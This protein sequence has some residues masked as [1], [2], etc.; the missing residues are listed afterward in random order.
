MNG[1]K[2]GIG[3][4][5]TEEQ[6]PQRQIE[7]FLK[8]G[9][10]ER[11]IF[12]DACTGNAGNIEKRDNYQRAKT[13]ARKGDVVFFDALDRLGRN[14]EEIKREWEYFT[15]EVEC[16]VVVMNMPILDTRK[17]VPGDTMGQM[18]SEIVLTIVSYIA[19]QETQERK[20][21]QTAGIAVAKANG[22]Y[23]GK[24][25]MKID[26]ELFEKLYKEVQRKERTATYAM[27]KMGV[28]RNTWYVLV[29]EYET[30]T[31]RFK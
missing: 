26:T 28:K 6:N 7:A 14:A 1:I 11:Y 16:D 9:I 15:K 23:K 27:E 5:S 4:V 12:I 30:K 8:E 18:V 13:I 19:E 10:D 25:P 29:K 20:R 3:R 24:A 2:I 31:G 17:K 22:K 21:R